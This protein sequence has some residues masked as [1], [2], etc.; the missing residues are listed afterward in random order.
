MMKIERR[1]DP[2]N[3]SSVLS[4]LVLQLVALKVAAHAEGES[5]NCALTGRE[6]G[7]ALAGNVGGVLAP[8]LS[9][10]PSARFLQVCQQVLLQVPPR[11]LLDRPP[12]R[13][14]SLFLGLPLPPCPSFK[15]AG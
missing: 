9:R 8:R 12:L 10:Y 14:H 7:G 11:R 13:G 5:R 2:K 4:D 15:G 3:Q 6:E 1:L